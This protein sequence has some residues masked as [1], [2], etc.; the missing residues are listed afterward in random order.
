MESEPLSDTDFSELRIIDVIAE[1]DDGKKIERGTQPEG[2]T[3][4]RVGKDHQ[5]GISLGDYATEISAHFTGKT[6]AYPEVS[7]ATGGQNPYTFM[8]GGEW[9]DSMYDGFVWQILNPMDVGH[10]A[11]VWSRSTIGVGIIGDF[12]TVGP[13][14]KQYISA[15]RLVGELCIMFW[16]DPKGRS[17][18]GYVLAGH[19]ERQGGSR[20]PG[21]KCPGKLWD[22]DEFR[23]DV[24]DWIQGG[25]SI[26]LATYGASWS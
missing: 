8:V 15:V 16:L 23:H 5:T 6:D 10:H 24:K 13:T 20:T 4:H 7:R 17:Q 11:R 3:I 18:D 12:R 2:I 1:C 9:A 25:A 22:M 21:K 19:D 26:R 14:R